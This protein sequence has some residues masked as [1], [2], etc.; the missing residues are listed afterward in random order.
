MSEL[1][2]QKIVVNERISESVRRGEGTS[3]NAKG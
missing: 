2:N 3:D 1:V